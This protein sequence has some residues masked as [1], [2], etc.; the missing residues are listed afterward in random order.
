MS[1]GRYFWERITAQPTHGTDS[2]VYQTIIE[3]AGDRRILIENHL[4]VITY[5]QEKI[6]V[7]VN[8]GSVAICGCALEI[9]HMSNEQLVI[10]G[11]IQ[12]ISLYRRERN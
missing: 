4:G 6:I 11:N 1:K 8:Y 10:F 12:S 7:K 9:T 5:G 3:V 2:T